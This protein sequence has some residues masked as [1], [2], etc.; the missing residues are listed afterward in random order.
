M[1][2]SVDPDT[3]LTLS[4]WTHRTAASCPLKWRQ[5]IKDW[6]RKME[7]LRSK[8]ASDRLY[9]RVDR[10]SP[11]LR[12]QTLSVLSYEPL[13]TRLE[14][15]CRH[16]TVSVW[17]IIVTLHDIPSHVLSSDKSHTWKTFVQR[18]LK[19]LRAKI[20][21]LQG[22]YFHHKLRVWWI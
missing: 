10:Q 17:P 19:Y 15:T 5:E 13:T 2:L 11:L 7:K 4:N 3:I 9:L 14:W 6:W 20:K 22:C 12:S 1:V 16:R 18:L 21:G 8:W